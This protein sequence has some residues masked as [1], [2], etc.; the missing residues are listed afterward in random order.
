MR[1]GGG[2]ARRC[3]APV[4]PTVNTHWL[5]AV[6]EH[7]LNYELQCLLKEEY[8]RNIIIPRHSSE[9]QVY[10]IL[11]AFAVLDHYLVTSRPRRGPNSYPPRW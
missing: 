10:L 2:W 1:L 4:I 5:T 6:M 11:F 7:E 8:T 3:T 9:P